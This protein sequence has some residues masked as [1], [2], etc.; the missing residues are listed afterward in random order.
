MIDTEKTAAYATIVAPVTAIG[1]SLADLTQVAQ[2][3]AYAGSALA[4]I[5]AFI[6]YMVKVFR[7]DK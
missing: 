1:I 3:A 6:Y 4:G 5:G 2:I 7:K